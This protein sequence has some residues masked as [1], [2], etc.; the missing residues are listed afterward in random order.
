MVKFRRKKINRYK[1]IKFPTSKQD[2]NA[3]FYSNFIKEYLE[4]KLEQNTSDELNLFQY[5]DFFRKQ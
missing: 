4:V 3:Q 2:A 5:K 1:K